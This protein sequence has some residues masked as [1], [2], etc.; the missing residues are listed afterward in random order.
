MPDMTTA[1]LFGIHILCKAGC[2]VLFDDN[3]CQVIY[4]S[5]VILTGY[6]NPDSDLWTLP[7]L[8]SEPT[9]TTPDAQH[10]LSLGPSMSDTPQQFFVT[11]Y[12]D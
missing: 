8:P 9:L 4:N 7:I 12:L 5:K 3:K 10:Q 2:K 11:L 6:K 1:S